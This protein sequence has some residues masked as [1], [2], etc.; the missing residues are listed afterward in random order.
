MVE[1]LVNNGFLDGNHLDVL[2]PHQFERFG[3]SATKIEDLGKFC[4]FLNNLNPL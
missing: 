2:S 3:N 1:L 4:T